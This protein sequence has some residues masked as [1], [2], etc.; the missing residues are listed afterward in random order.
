MQKTDRI[1]AILIILVSILFGY[2]AMR[3]PGPIGGRGI[4]PGG[5]P[6]VIS[7]ALL[8]CGIALLYRSCRNVDPQGGSFLNWP[9]FTKNKNFYIVL[10]ATFAYPALIYLLGYV[11]C[12]FLFLSVLIRILGRLS[13]K[14]VGLISILSTAFLY[15]AFKV[16]FYM[17]FPRG[18]FW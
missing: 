18:F 10:I 15:L 3:L 1:T 16:W 5:M 2:Q 4:G 8:L 17:P 6:L 12:T 13:W 9:R 14:V 7:M 11:I